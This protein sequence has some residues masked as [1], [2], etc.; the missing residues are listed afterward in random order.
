[1]KADEE[2]R[3][4]IALSLADSLGPVAFKAL[5]G[6]YKKPSRILKARGS[7]LRK[8]TGL[9]DA[10]VKE[11]KDAK[12][13]EKADREIEK[14]LKQDVHIVTCFDEAYPEELKAIYDPPIALYVKGRLPD[15]RLPKVAVVGSR[16]CSLYGRGMAHGISETL[17]HNGVVVVSGLALG[18]DS[19]AHEGALSGDGITIAVLGGGLSKLYPPDNKQLAAKIVEKGAVISEYPMEMEPLKQYFPRRNRIISGLSCGVLVVEAKEKSGALITANLA[20]EEGRD[21]FA[22]PGNADSA[23]SQGTNSLL[24]QGAKLVTSAADILEELEL[25]AR[26]LPLKKKAPAPSHPVSADEETILSMVDGDARH[27]DDLIE[28]IGWPSARV[29]AAL[30]LLEIKGLVRQLPG[31]H[32]VTA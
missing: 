30:S 22:V 17:A 3:E 24:K 5:I 11:I 2:L 21:V 10:A 26:R 9:K 20:L 14:A 19:A 12:L 25:S 28:G 16:V 31:K 6:K 4:T 8:V 15:A 23:R 27:V 29:I 32:F 18:I 1:M 13:L 7:D